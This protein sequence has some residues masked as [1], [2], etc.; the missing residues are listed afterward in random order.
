MLLIGILM[1][2]VHNVSSEFNMEVNMDFTGAWNCA[3]HTCLF[4]TYIR[5]YLGRFGNYHQWGTRPQFCHDDIYFNENNSVGLE[6][7][8]DEEFMSKF[9]FDPKE[10]PVISK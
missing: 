10:D 6:R 3:D 7:A 9:G 4:V 1:C 2:V 5:S 8:G